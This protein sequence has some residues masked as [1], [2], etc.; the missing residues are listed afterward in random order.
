[1]PKTIDVD[2]LEEIRMIVIDL[3][4]AFQRIAKE[5]EIG[6]HLCH[7]LHNQIVE[8]RNGMMIPEESEN[9]VEESS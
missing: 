4:K 3:G 5:G 1:M 7:K 8:L 6:N 9:G 2:S